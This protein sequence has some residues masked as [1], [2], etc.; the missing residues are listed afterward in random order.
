MLSRATPERAI[1]HFQRSDCSCSAIPFWLIPSLA[2]AAL[3]AGSA[4]VWA[5][6][7]VTILENGFVYENPAYPHVDH[8]YYYDNVP[9]DNDMP[10]LRQFAA[11][12]GIFSLVNMSLDWKDREFDMIQ[13]IIHYT[14]HEMHWTGSN[15]CT[16]GWR[17]KE[18]LTVNEQDPT[19]NWACGKIAVVAIGLAQA[20]GIPARFVGGS[21]DY[22]SH[23][24]CLE[25]FSTRYNRWV[26][27]FQHTY[28]WIEH[29]TDGPLG[30]RELQPCDQAG[31]IQLEWIDGKRWAVPCP[32]LVFQP[33]G[34]SHAPVWPYYS[35]RWWSGYFGH[36][37]I[38]WTTLINRPGGYCQFIVTDQ[39]TNQDLGWSAPV[40]P[41]YELDITYPL[42]NVEADV[43]LSGDDVLVT[44]ENN[45]FE[46]VEYQMRIDGGLWQPLNLAQPDPLQ[47][48]YLWQ[49]IGLTATLSIRGVNLAGAHSPDVVLQYIGPVPVPILSQLGLIMLGLIIL[50]AGAIVLRRRET[51]RV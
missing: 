24:N 8:G 48:T 33:S 46:F 30:A 13:A 23:D 5:E 39:W 6:A 51:T 43:A 10:W 3:L 28:G 25:M 27:V 49:P 44:L 14:S 26:F 41:V 32:P 45:M 37:W 47:E 18:I 7:T 31:M 40:V 1:V 38:S 4:N 20:Q 21:T 35:A 11:S 29:E 19:C 15:T 9:D 22:H 2:A 34:Y 36:M 42:N 17:A 16:A 50:G 12:H